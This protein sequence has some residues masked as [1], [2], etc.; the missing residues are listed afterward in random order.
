MTTAVS[1]T[2]FLSFSTWLGGFPNCVVPPPPYR[3]FFF[4]AVGRPQFRVDSPDFYQLSVILRIPATQ[5]SDCCQLLRDPSCLP[6]YFSSPL[7]AS[8]SRAPSH[9]ARK[10]IRST[11]IIKGRDD[12]T[13]EDDD[14]EDDA[15]IGTIN[16]PY[17]CKLTGSQQQGTIV[18]LISVRSSLSITSVLF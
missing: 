14:S 2:S 9:K 10:S 16:Q 8:I 5:S 17:E 18:I 6:N 12:Q 13:E 15:G 7:G 4:S 1:V 11:W 3:F